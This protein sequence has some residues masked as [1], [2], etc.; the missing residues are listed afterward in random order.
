MLEEVKNKCGV[1]IMEHAGFKARLMKA[2]R[3]EG[4]G[5][6][7]LPPGS[8]I[9]VFPIA[10]LPGCPDGWVREAGTYVCPVSSDWGLWFD[11]T[12]NDKLNTAVIPSVKGMN[13][14]TGTKLE[15]FGMEQYADKCPVHDIPFTHGRICSECG[16]EWPP[17]NYITQSSGWLWFDGMRQADGSVRQFF[18]TADDERD[19][20]SAVIGKENT[21]P[22]FGFAFYQT[23][24]PIIP[25]P[26]KARRRYQSPLMKYGTKMVGASSLKK[27]VKKGILRAKTVGY[28][29]GS[30]TYDSRPLQE[31]TI[32]TIPTQDTSYVY[33]SNSTGEDLTPGDLKEMIQSFASVDEHVDFAPQSMYQQVIEDGI[34]PEELTSRGIDP[35]V[36]ASDAQEI[37]EEE[38]NKTVSVGAGAKIKQEIKQ[39]KLGIDAWKDQPSAVIRLYFCFEPQF[40]DII[41]KGGFK[42]IKNDKEGFLKGVKVG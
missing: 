15:G 36:C 33:T 42:E 18:F 17:Q 14:I 4:D 21:V 26:P 39:D 35:E 32:D 3:L 38:V 9:T 2:K 25:E 24:N 22:A 20:A 10:C 12:M 37:K 41:K 16:Y 7:D 5:V 30:T 19:V 34:E 28:S 29:S 13:P 6:F 31:S 8:P 1:S 23:K 11:W 40:L 27:S